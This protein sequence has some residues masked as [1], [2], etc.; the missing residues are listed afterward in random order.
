MSEE[1]MKI[2]AMLQ[3]GKISVDE[4]SR[5][6]D[7]F[8]VETNTTTHCDPFNFTGTSNVGSICR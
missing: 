8:E 6:I 7:V 1:R 5:L 2:L 3:D 4:A